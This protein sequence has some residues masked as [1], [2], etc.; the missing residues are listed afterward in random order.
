MTRG[1]DSSQLFAYFLKRYKTA[2]RLVARLSFNLQTFF[3]L[4]REENFVTAMV[5]S[6]IC[7]PILPGQEVQVIHA[8]MTQVKVLARQV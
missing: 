7:G 3:Q 5:I 8:A 4:A 2:P 1:I 6:L